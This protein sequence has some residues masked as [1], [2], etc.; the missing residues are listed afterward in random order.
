M[1]RSH[2]FQHLID[3]ALHCHLKGFGI[4]ALSR[5]HELSPDEAIDVR[6]V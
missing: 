3:E 6:L 5:P 1:S 2:P 4:L